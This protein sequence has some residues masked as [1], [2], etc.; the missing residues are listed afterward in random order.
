M[1]NTTTEVR[2]TP[3]LVAEVRSVLERHGYRLPDEGDHVHGLVVARV[4]AA[5]R[6]LVEVF[7]GRT[8]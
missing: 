1:G 3:L 2:F 4:D 7:E 6:N 8:W 5:L